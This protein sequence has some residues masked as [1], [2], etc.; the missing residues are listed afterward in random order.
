MAEQLS[1]VLSSL[2]V[3]Q[4]AIHIRPNG[5][6]DVTRVTQRILGCPR[7][8]QFWWGA[9]RRV[10]AVGAVEQPTDLSVMVS[11][12]TSTNKRGARFQ[13]RKLTKAIMIL[14][15]WDADSEHILVG[16]YVPERKLIVF[17]VDG[18]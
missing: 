9:R 3:G 14:A 12:F 16:E 15:G 7:Y 18:R 1:S 10:L 6:F 13:N 11:D 5:K 4:L 17:P 8:I 2:P